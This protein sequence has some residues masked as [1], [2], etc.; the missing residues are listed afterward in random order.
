LKTQL[1]Q[2]QRFLSIT[3]LFYKSVFAYNII[4]TIATQVFMSINGLIPNPVSLF[5][6]K[7]VGM[8]SAIALN[9]YQYKQS[10]FY[11]RNAGYAMRQIIVSALLLDVLGYISIAFLASSI[12]KVWHL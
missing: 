6:A 1:N 5:L 11:Y 2:L 10:Y 12:L 9:N 7:I 3:F 4:F 8:S